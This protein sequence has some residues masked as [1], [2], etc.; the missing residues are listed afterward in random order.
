MKT[1]GKLNVS[2]ENFGKKKDSE[3]LDET[4]RI[5]RALHRKDRPSAYELTYDEWLKD[6]E[7]ASNPKSFKEAGRF[8]RK[9]RLCVERILEQLSRS[10]MKTSG[11]WCDLGDLYDVRHHVL[12][13]LLTAG[14]VS[15]LAYVEYRGPYSHGMKHWY[16]LTE[17]IPQD[18]RVFVVPY[19]NE[20]EQENTANKSQ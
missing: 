16:Y 7:K 17:K 11:L 4:T 3:T 10:P 2:M 12:D 8:V 9:Y 1:K 14:T 20:K 5:Y 19:K 6:I 13:D 18:K 15:I